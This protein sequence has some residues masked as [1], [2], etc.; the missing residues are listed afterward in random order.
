MKVQ[1]ELLQDPLEDVIVDGRVLLP[2][3]ERVSALDWRMDTLALAPQQSVVMSQH[4]EWLLVQILLA[5]PEV[6]LVG[7]VC[8][9]IPVYKDS[10]RFRAPALLCSGA[11]LRIRPS[12]HLVETEEIVNRSRYGVCCVGLHKTL[13]F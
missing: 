12:L 5:G 2:T 8:L 3:G 10:Q 4:E 11:G 7:D 1:V 6:S 9:E 13:V